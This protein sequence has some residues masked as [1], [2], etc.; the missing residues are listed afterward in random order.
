MLGGI[1]VNLVDRH[2]GVNHVRLNSFCD[3]VRRILGSLDGVE[4]TYAC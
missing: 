4:M 2:G 1:V 3:Y